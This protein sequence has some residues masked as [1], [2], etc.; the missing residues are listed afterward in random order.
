ML[1]GEESNIFPENH[2]ILLGLCATG[3]MGVSV[4]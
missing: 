1:S 4:T 3:V 2:T